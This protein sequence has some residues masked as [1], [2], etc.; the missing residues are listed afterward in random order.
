MSVA[1]WYCVI[2]AGCH[3]AALFL[4]AQKLE[5]LSNAS[6]LRMYNQNQKT[7]WKHKC[8]DQVSSQ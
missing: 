7:E 6:S 1:I 5:K 4:S 3:V 8:F 2:V